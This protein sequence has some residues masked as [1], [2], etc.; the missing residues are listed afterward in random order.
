MHRLLAQWPL[1]AVMLHEL[2]ATSRSPF[3]R[4]RPNNFAAEAE[5]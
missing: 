2:D 1:V 4:G 5:H 3:R